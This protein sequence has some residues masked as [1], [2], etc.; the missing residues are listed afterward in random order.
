MKEQSAVILYLV[1]STTMLWIVVIGLLG[2]KIWELLRKRVRI[3]AV[4]MDGSGNLKEE[5]ELGKQKEILI[6]KSTPANLV[7]IDFSDSQYAS[8]IQEE[9]ASF[10]RWGAFWY[11][12]SKAENGM[13]GLKQGGSDIVYKLR[14]NTPYRIHRG[15]I[16]F[17]SYEKIVIQ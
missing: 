14:R 5:Y 1:I 13:V 11:V 9:H 4:V 10:Q 7:H 6:G 17:I 3:K 16:V 8:T 15:D 12:Y 2:I